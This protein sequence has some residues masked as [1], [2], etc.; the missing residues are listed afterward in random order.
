MAKENNSEIL[1]KFRKIDKFAVDIL[2]NNRLFLSS[3]T[4]L[5][6]PHEAEMLIE[7]PNINIHANPKGLQ[8]FD[9]RIIQEDLIS[10]EISHPRICSLSNVWHSNLAWSHYTDG[11]T[12]I[13]IGLVLPDLDDMEKIEIKYDSKLPVI[14]DYPLRKEDVIEALSHKSEEW[15]YEE[16]IRLVTFDDKK[17]FVENIQIKEVIFGLRTDKEDMKLVYNILENKQVSFFKTCLQPG[18]YQLCKADIYEFI[19]EWEKV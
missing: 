4:T 17:H 9:K 2:V 11:H 19:R 1:Y 7:T 8:R 5:N 13:A 6:D 18:K 12:G 15:K 14:Q 10:D 3:W 16:E